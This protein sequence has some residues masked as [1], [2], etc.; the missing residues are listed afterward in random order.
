MFNMKIKIKLGEKSIHSS[1]DGHFSR[2]HILAT[3][4]ETEMHMG[5]QLA[6]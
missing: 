4:K 3:V 5:E 2:F 1:V 6:L